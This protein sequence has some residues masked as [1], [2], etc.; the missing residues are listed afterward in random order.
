MKDSDS[1][2]ADIDILKERNYECILDVE[3]PPMKKLDFWEQARLKEEEDIKQ[4]N[5]TS[6][7]IRQAE[8]EAEE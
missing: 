8:I 2:D 6:Y 4:I 5:F 3:Q 7:S 1:F